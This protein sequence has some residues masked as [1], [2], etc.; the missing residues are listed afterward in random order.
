MKDSPGSGRR[1]KCFLYFAPGS[2]QKASRKERKLNEGRGRK[3][4]LILLSVAL[5]SNMTNSTQTFSC[6]RA[7]S[8]IF[9]LITTNTKK[10]HNS[11]CDIIINYRSCCDLTY[12]R[13]RG[14]ILVPVLLFVDQRPEKFQF[15]T[16]RTRISICDTCRPAQSTKRPKARRLRLK[17]K[18]DQIS[19]ISTPIIVRL[20]GYLCVKWAVLCYTMQS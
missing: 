3:I 7:S 18:K 15:I 9:Q 12:G 10:W 6:L 2:V 19:E 20:R 16:R 13:S 5:K 8:S 1:G 4:H 17:V 14:I 11:L